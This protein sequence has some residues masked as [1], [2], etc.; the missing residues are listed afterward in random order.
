MFVA[1]RALVGPILVLV[2]ALGCGSTRDDPTADDQPDASVAGDAL[3]SVQVDGHGRVTSEPPGIDCPGT[4]NALFAP[5]S[6][7]KLTA[8][9]D[10]QHAFLG[11]DAWTCSTESECVVPVGT[12]P[13]AARFT[14]KYNVVFTSSAPMRDGAFGSVSADQQCHDLAAKSG[15]PGTYV[16]WLSTANA[17]ARTRIGNAS[18]WITTAGLPFARDR[19]AL[20]A[21]NILYPAQW[22]ETRSKIAVPVFTGTDATGARTGF[23]CG[24]WTSTSGYTEVG[25]SDAVDRYFTTGTTAA[26]DAPAHLLCLG[27]DY[28]TAVDVL[29]HSGRVAFLAPLWSSGNGAADADATCQLAAASASREGTYRAFLATSSG[30]PESRMNLD[31]APWITVDGLR[32]VAKPDQLSSGLLTTIDSTATGDWGWGYVFVGLVDE[33]CNDW[34][35]TATGTY[36]RGGVNYRA[37]AGMWNSGVRAPLNCSSGGF[38]YC[39]EQAAQPL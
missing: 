18:G 38:L 33:N 26:C 28:Q 17:D 9:A 31:G 2:A 20:D 1:G 27:V 21:A 4:C 6:S 5:G 30:T 15:L 37:S 11:W 24:G 14:G 16:A 8:T 36:V 3:L 22:D 7:V 32:L 10:Q 39:F 25:Y 13:I 12:N 34:T 19:A 29:V 35:Q 23:T